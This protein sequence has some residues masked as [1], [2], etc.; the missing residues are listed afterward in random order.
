VEIQV[1]QE[2]GVRGEVKVERKEEVKCYELLNLS[3]L[4]FILFYFIF[5]LFIRC[6]RAYYQIRNS[7]SIGKCERK[8]MCTNK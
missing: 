5:L 8:I 1:E 7:D 2:R 6:A 3:K 4:I